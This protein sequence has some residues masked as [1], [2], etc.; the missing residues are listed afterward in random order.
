MDFLIKK[1][2]ILGGV[3]QKKSEKNAG[4]FK[5]QVLTCTGISFFV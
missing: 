5:K 3:S 2:M 4:S 1:I